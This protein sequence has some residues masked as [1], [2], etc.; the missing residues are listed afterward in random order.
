VVLTH[1]DADHLTGLLEVLHCFQVKQ[2]LYPESDSESTLYDEW[3]GL[4]AEKNIRHTTARAGQEIDLGKGVTINVLNPQV[5]P[6]PDTESDADNNSVVLRL[7]Q[8][9]VSFLLTADI[10]QEAEWELI[11]QRAELNST[12]LKVAHHGSNTSTTPEF[13]AVVNPRLAVIS[14]GADNRFGHPG[15][16]VLDRLEKKPGSANIYRTDRH[17]TIAFTTDGE[18]LWVEAEEQ[19]PD[20]QDKA[21]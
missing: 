9:R 14:V 4:I 7:S 15:V 17:G 10:R 6:L 21:K 5:F 8:G 18:R 13:L 19:R 20:W 12:V 3:L 16:E 1:P 2:V 11:R